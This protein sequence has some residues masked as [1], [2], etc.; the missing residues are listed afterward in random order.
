MDDKNH[1]AYLG[2]LKH[3]IKQLI[4]QKNWP[5]TLDGLAKL[6]QLAPLALETRGL[7]LEYL[8]AAEQRLDAKNLAKQLIQ[9]FPASSRI[10]YLAGLLAYREKDYRAALPAFEES[11]R[12]H[13]NWRTER[14]IGKTSTQSG[15]FELAEMKL[16]PLATK[17]PVCLLD[18]AWLYE[19][20]QQYSRAQQ[21]IEQYLKY[22]PED[23]YATLQLQRLQAQVLSVDQITEEVETLTDFGEDIPIGL[24]AEYL[25]NQLELGK[26]HALRQWLQ[27]RLEHIDKKD[28]VKLAWIGYQLKTYDL[29]YVLFLK[30]FA[31]QYNNVKYRSALELSAQRSGQVENLMTLYE[32][33]CELDNRFYG[34]LAKLRKKHSEPV[35]K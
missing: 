1:N 4:H 28:S 31:G 34:R 35:K 19:R 11:F 33:Y 15:N 14:Y 16:L 10:H 27:P 30:D 6:K 7:E 17:H 25:R 24:L 29:A 26:G 9:L 13:P 23:D 12:L 20:Q 8:V 3:N 18:L 5:A 32:Q 2:A 21:N 22:K